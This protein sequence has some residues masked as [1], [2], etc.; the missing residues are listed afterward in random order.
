MFVY[1]GVPASVK[2]VDVMRGDP[3]SR[4]I[5]S[6]EGNALRA[7]MVDTLNEGR[8]GENMYFQNIDNDQDDKNRVSETN[9]ES[10][11]FGR[12]SQNT[13]NAVNQNNQELTV[14]QKQLQIINAHSEW[15]ARLGNPRVNQK[16]KQQITNQKQGIHGSRNNGYNMTRE[17][18]TDIG[19]ENVD[20]RRSMND[21]HDN[22]DQ[23]RFKNDPHDSQRMIGH[24]R[25]PIREPYQDRDDKSSYEGQKLF[26]FSTQQQF[27]HS[28]TSLSGNND[29]TEDEY[30]D[31]IPLDWNSLSQRDYT[32]D[33][34]KDLHHSPVISSQPFLNFHRDSEFSNSNAEKFRLKSNNNDDKCVEQSNDLGFI[35]KG[36]IVNDHDNDFSLSDYTSSNTN[37]SGGMGPF[38][39][40]LGG[41]DS[42]SSRLLN[43]DV[44]VNHQNELNMSG[45]QIFPLNQ[46]ENNDKLSSTSIPLDKWTIKAWLP[47]AFDGFDKTLINT[48]IS[49]LRDDG[50]FV[51][52]QDLLDYQS[53]GELTRE[54]LADIAGFKVGHWNRFEKT[55]APYKEV[56]SDL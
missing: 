29:F 55:L 16:Q 48:F 38:F 1:S 17:Y 22:G 12:S 31:D 56:K 4:F 42:S 36:S 20:Q 14:A 28:I 13:V 11:E 45:S 41:F 30:T 5:M 7:M 49:K 2:L 39:G 50:G 8:I 46:H 18:L 51:T 37:D 19:R 15:K 26:N 47:I 32:S 24:G 43:N 25:P 33:K 34:K 21:P 10:H 52:V 35:R 27:N 3:I 23:R 40:G 54:A 9:G 44:Y 6:G 53:K